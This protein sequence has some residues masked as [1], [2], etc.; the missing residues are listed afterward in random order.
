MRFAAGEL[1][2]VNGD[3]LAFTARARFA[4]TLGQSCAGGHFRNHEASAMT[5]DEAA[6]WR[7]G[8]PRHRRQNDVIR[9]I[10]RSDLQVFGFNLNVFVPNGK[11]A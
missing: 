4:L 2:D 3:A 8:Y 11:A 9:N 1:H 7:I 10:Y 5:L 6:E